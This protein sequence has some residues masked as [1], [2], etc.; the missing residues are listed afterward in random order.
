MR[1]LVVGINPSTAKK[2]W[3]TTWKRL[4]RWAD[5]LGIG[6]FSFTNCLYEQGSYSIRDVDYDSLIECTRGH[7]RVIA[8]GGFVSKVLSKIN[9]Q[10]FTLPHPSGL[11]RKLND[12]SYELEQLESCRKYIYG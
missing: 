8:L 11:N 9:V 4:P 7:E 5:H 3:S 1:V 6:V 10:H 2:G 12:K